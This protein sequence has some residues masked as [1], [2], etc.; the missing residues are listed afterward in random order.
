MWVR[1]ILR[2]PGVSATVLLAFG[3]LV[4]WLDWF[5]SRPALL[6][7]RTDEWTDVAV[8]TPED[9]QSREVFRAAVAY[10]MITLRLE[11]EPVLHAK[12]A[13]DIKQD[14]SQVVAAD[15]F[16]PLDVAAKLLWRP[17]GPGPEIVAELAGLEKARRLVGVRS[18]LRLSDCAARLSAV[19]CPAEQWSVLRVGTGN[20]ARRLAGATD[21]S[22]PSFLAFSGF[23]DPILPGFGAWTA[24]SLRGRTDDRFRLVPP[25]D[26]AA[27]AAQDGVVID[28]IGGD[29]VMVPQMPEPQR[30]CWDPEARDVRTQPCEPG[31]TGQVQVAQRFALD[32]GQAA[33]L[34][35]IEVTGIT[36]PLIPPS[37]ARKVAGG[38]VILP[39]SDHVRLEC[40][41]GRPSGGGWTEVVPGKAWCLPVWQPMQYSERRLARDLTSVRPPPVALDAPQAEVTDEDFV[42]PDGL[43]RRNPDGNLDLSARARA[44][45][46]QQVLGVPEAAFGS[47]LAYLEQLPPEVAP[48]DLPVTFDMAMTAVVAK[49]F[50]DLAAGGRVGDASL[51]ASHRRYDGRRRMAFAL[52]DLRT[53]ST[54]GAVRVA[55]SNPPYDE[56]VAI[57]D[58][59]AATAR[60]PADSPLIPKAWAGLDSRFMPGSTMKVL[61]ALAL[62]DSVT[63]RTAGIDD[64]LRESL[65]AALVGT[66]NQTYTGKLG[67]D[68]EQP[69]YELPT[70]D[71]G[72]GGMF[73]V[74]DASRASPL[75]ASLPESLRNICAAPEPSA[76]IPRRGTGAAYGLCEAVAKSSNIW[77]AGISVAQNRAAL[78]YLSGTPEA[79]AVFSAHGQTLMRLGLHRP[80]GL[81]RVRDPETSEVRHVGPA[82]DAVDLPSAPGLAQGDPRNDPTAKGTQHTL[83]TGLN[84]YG[85]NVQMAPVA[86]AAISGSVARNEIVLPFIASQT[87]TPITPEPL[88]GPEDA[89]Y[90]DILRAG[91]KA[92][93][94][95][96]GTAAGTIGA[97]RP[98]GRALRDRLYAKTG[99][100]TL[101][102][103]GIPDGSSV[104][105][106]WFTGWIADEAGN[107]AFAF[108]CAISHVPAQPVCARMTVEILAQMSEQ[109]LL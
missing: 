1:R 84:A 93:V 10:G 57:F 24:A 94:E 78:D 103:H 68:L 83:N 67:V 60:R 100:A 41:G 6:F 96:G 51:N 105:S 3:A 88:Y 43:I 90:L 35:Y 99:T 52:I 38:R 91:M 23:S 63:G 89:P 42:T 11:P 27:R 48:A 80:L 106:S 61:S 86:L 37:I 97:A 31:N 5:S 79:A 81:V 62:I 98:P 56:T 9:D 29:V 32:R 95:P 66:G 82:M 7:E 72:S 75:G 49:A 26:F 39:L 17:R 12:S 76:N 25:Q 77:F 65:R 46:L 58:A 36:T 87:G 109:G 108:A 21:L 28:V 45:G 19:D 70:A 59:L 30:Y 71:A 2:Q 64:D 74:N 47:Y 14:L 92:V 73:E 69:S 20:T 44:A 50:G 104:Y 16:L 40:T 18:T 85:Q 34:Q 22:H 4:W 33:T 15:G 107:P 54:A 55:Y 53:P 101:E 102:G 13:L 8:V